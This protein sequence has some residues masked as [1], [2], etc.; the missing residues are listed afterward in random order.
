MSRVEQARRAAGM[1]QNAAAA[2]L[3]VSYP[4]YLKKEQDPSL[5]AFGELE[6]LGNEMDG[7]SRQILWSALEE[8]QAT[9]RERRSIEE[10]TLGEFYRARSGA[11]KLESE[12]EALRAKN[13]AQGV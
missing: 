8:V 1:T 13:F 3:G 4:T 5:M 2:I 9:A 11:S 12:L 10:L 6:A 7:L